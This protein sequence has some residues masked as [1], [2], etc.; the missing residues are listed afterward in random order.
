VSLWC[1]MVLGRGG[2]A[3][4]ASCRAGVREERGQARGVCSGTWCTLWVR[5]AA[6]SHHAGMD[7]LHCTVRLEQN[8]LGELV[9]WVVAGLAAR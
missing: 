7:G 6:R 9:L 4:A 8:W 5:W 1:T 2:V 3:S